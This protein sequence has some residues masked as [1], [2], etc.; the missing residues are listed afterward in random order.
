MTRLGERIALLTCLLAT[1]SGCGGAPP[2]PPTDSSAILPAS[3]P[4]KFDTVPIAQTG[5]AAPPVSILDAAEATDSSVTFT[6]RGGVTPSIS[7]SYTTEPVIQCGSGEPVTVSGAVVLLVRFFPTDAHEFSGEQA[8][9]T[10]AD[11]NRIL[12]GP[13]LR[14]MTLVCDFEAQVEWAIGLSRRAG[15]RLVD[16]AGPGLFVIEFDRH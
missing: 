7:V 12:G 3:A 5:D 11:R 6:V 16:S 14:Q 8:I 4:P 9:A 2:A 15:F 10:I 13:L 1:S